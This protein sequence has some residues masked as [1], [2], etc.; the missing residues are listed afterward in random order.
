VLG[1]A[2]AVTLVILVAR[3][4]GRGA[5]A[6]PLLAVPLIAAGPLCT[7]RVWDMPCSLSGIVRVE[8][9][10][11]V[12][13]AGVW[14]GVGAYLF[15][16]RSMCASAAAFRLHLRAAAFVSLSA[17]PLA[18]LAWGYAHPLSLPS[19]ALLFLPLPLAFVGGCA[20]VLLALA[21]HFPPRRAT[22]L[23]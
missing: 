2:L 16:L 22:V 11:A 21:S 14:L 6:R 1:A 8:L 23:A 3:A 7:M 19:P 20:A 13:G 12:L 18:W 17:A 5:G 10:V 15:V 4:V 9:L